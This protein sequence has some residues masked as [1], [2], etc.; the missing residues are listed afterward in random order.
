[1]VGYLPTCNL[2]LESRE[3]RKGSIDAVELESH[4]PVLRASHFTFDL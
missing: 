3:G 2:Y 1:M 4:M